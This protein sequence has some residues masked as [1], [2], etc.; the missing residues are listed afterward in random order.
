VDHAVSPDGTRIAY[1][2]GG[3]GE[4]VLFVHGTIASS[5]DWAFVSRLLRDRFT[6]V[7]MDRRGRGQSDFG[8]EPYSIEREGEDV[9]A[10]MAATGARKVVGHSYGGLCSLTALDQGAPIDRLVLY[11]PPV[12]VRPDAATQHTGLG[13]H[14]SAG[15]HDEAAAGFLAAAGAS[16]E[17]V[18]L[19]RGSPV[20]PAL[21]DAVPS[22]ARELATAM[23]WTTPAG[24]FDIPALLII[25]A[26]STSRSYLDGVPALEAAF[27]QLRRVALPG[28]KH[29]G[30]VLAAEA[31][32]AMAGDFLG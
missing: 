5:S 18:A 12:S 16:A 8:A 32:A 31:F 25:G 27:P 2:T 30:H 28:Q 17:E 14:L 13:E 24:P 4:P 6:T 15:R 19:I 26:E 22:V 3:A 21:L 10:V 9:A 29:L 1:R 11:E 7:T 20:W 23:G